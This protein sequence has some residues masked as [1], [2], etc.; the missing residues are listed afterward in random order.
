MIL[1]V[2]MSQL[3]LAAGWAYGICWL[4]NKLKG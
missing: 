2:M 3:L 4:L 1:S